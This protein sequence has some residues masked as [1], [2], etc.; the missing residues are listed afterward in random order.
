MPRFAV[1]KYAARDFLAFEG[2]GD[3]AEAA[4]IH[5]G[6][7]CETA[8]GSGVL[9]VAQLVQPLGSEQQVP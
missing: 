2:C 5:G 8:R 1:E 3:H 6:Q 9:A 4:A 7:A